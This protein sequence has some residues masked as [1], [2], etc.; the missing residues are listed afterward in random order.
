M[1][2]IG[3]VFVAFLYIVILMRAGKIASRCENSFPAFLA[4]G[5][6]FLLV[7]QALFNMAVA[8]GLALLLVSHYH[9]LVKVELQP[10]LIVFILECC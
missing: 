10:L 2:I 3:A 6:A 5:I 8:V 1:G 7:T 9:L 4:M